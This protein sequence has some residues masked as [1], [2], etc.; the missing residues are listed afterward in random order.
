MGPQYVPARNRAPNPVYKD[1]L[2]KIL[3]GGIYTKN[4]FQDKGRYTLLTLPPMVFDL[5]NGFPIITERDI[6]K[7]WKTP[8]AE[9]LAFIHGA[10][11]TK[12]LNSRGCK[13][14]NKWATPEKCAEF[15]L[16]PGDLGPGSYGAAFHDYPDLTNG[17]TFNQFE[18]LIKQIKDYPSLSTHK[19]T[20]WIP[21]LTLGHKSRQR[22]VVVAPCHGDVEVTILD[23]K[24]YLRMDQRSGDFPIGVPSNMIQYAALTMMI[25]HI[26]GYEPYT[27]IH[28]VHNAQI[29]ENQVEQMW[30]M[31]LRKTRNFP[32]VTLTAEGQRVTD[33]FDFRP[34]HFVLS[35][36]DPHPAIPDIPTT[37]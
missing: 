23:N 7:F 5:P 4:P 9:L 6:G 22:K 13:W 18:N 32:T 36:Y 31:I 12:E 37:T 8:I 28:A 20:T 24:L 35:D 15:G 25:A 19:V 10:R 17:G 11:T 33:L 21:S 30:Y 26:T 27:Y 29:Y 16:E 1:C 2:Q 14:W 34:D 3:E